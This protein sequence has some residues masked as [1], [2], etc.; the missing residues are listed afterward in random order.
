MRG[1]NSPTSRRATE[2][3]AS[4]DRE[5]TSSLRARARATT[6]RRQR[7]PAL[8]VSG[9]P[10]PRHRAGRGAR[11][12]RA[13]SPLSTSSNPSAITV[14]RSFSAPSKALRTN[15]GNRSVAGYVPS[16]DQLEDERQ[17]RR[18][19]ER[20]LPEV[21]EDVP[22][23]GELVILAAAE[24]LRIESPAVAH[25]AVEERRSGERVDADAPAAVRTAGEPLGRELERA[26]SV[27][28]GAPRAEELLVLVASLEVEADLLPVDRRE[29]RVWTACETSGLCQ[30]TAYSP[31]FAEPLGSPEN[32][33]MPNALAEP[34][35][36]SPTPSAERVAPPLLHADAST[37]ATQAATASRRAGHR[38]DRLVPDHER[39]QQL[40]RGR[41]DLVHRPVERPLRSPATASRTR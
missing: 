33:S 12:P 14:R 8:R 13:P 9:A 10:R 28:V 1:T 36:W 31:Q 24:V 23:A 25:V 15:A 7:A 27:D 38:G 40:A 17:P 5:P 37:A 11:R 21:R 4:P 32:R 18:R 22:L 2:A 35:S 19:S 29:R 30:P 34:T 39:R 26:V 41:R 16:V 20:E 6:S 3:R